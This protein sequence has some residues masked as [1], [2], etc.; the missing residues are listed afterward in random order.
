LLNAEIS[1]TAI[2]Q[3]LINFDSQ[4]NKKLQQQLLVIAA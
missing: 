2:E 1:H 4:K 3:V